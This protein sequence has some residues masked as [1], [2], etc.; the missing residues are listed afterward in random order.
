[1]ERFKIG[2]DPRKV[3]TEA[4]MN[5][6]RDAVN[7]T[8]ENKERLSGRGVKGEYYEN[9]EIRIKY[10]GSK[11]LNQFAAVA[12]TGLVLTPENCDEFATAVPTFTAGTMTAALADSP[13]AICRKPANPGEITKAVLTGVTPARVTI[14]DAAHQFAKPTPD[15]EAGALESCE[16]GT[17]RIVWKAGS[18]GEQWCILQ[19]GAGGAGGGEYNGYFKIVNA[20]VTDENGKTSN[21]IRIVDGATYNPQ[22]GISGK[23]VCKVNNAV[24]E[25]ETFSADVSAGKTYCLKYTA[26]AEAGGVT[27][28]AAAKVE[29]VE[30][31][32]MPSD[33][34]KNAYYQIGRTIVTNGTMKIA[35][36]HTAGVAQ[37]YWYLLCSEDE[38]KE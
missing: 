28:A 15:S 14:K 1:M 37:I 6:I 10:T 27:P 20:S 30:L 7:W 23:S 8:R 22:T 16:S 21:R 4:N 36:D 31:D 2:M 13:F 19:I 38:A 35:Q 9:G 32:A 17:A 33:D 18:S 34:T 24:F 11:T 29:I 12:L 5:E 26:A 3:I 25:I